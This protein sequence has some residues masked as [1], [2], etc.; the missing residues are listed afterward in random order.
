MTDEPKVTAAVAVYQISNEYLKKCIDSLCAQTLKEIEILL[1]SDHTCEENL[2]LLRDYQAFDKR[3]RVIENR[4]NRGLSAVR[5]QAA[6]EAKGTYICFVDGDDWMEKDMLEKAYVKSSLAGFPD[7]TVW[8]FS[9]AQ[10]GITEHTDY[11]GPKEKLFLGKEIKSLQL[12]VLDPTYLTKSL[13]LP[14]FGTAWAKLFKTEFLRK[15][16]D[17]RFPEHMRSGGEDLP[18]IYQITGR[19]DKVLLLEEYG[20][21]YRQHAASITKKYHSGEWH[22]RCAWMKELGQYIHTAD[23]CHRYAYERFCL[24]QL[25]AQIVIT[26]NHPECPLGLHLKRNA[27]KEMV[28]HP[29]ISQALSDLN[30]LD[31]KQTKWIYF[32]CIQLKLYLFV[33]AVSSCLHISLRNLF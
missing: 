6:A 5:N 18:F 8:S 30:S 12:Q 26:F 10:N 17:V 9:A 24:E 13:Q 20:Y 16:A 31:Y 14:M 29:Y 22:R 4:K 32:K 1:V 3:V 25:L 33:L 11:I 27:L 19:A 21:Y 2:A 23:A 15:H 28:K 7:M